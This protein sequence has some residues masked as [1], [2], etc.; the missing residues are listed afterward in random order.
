[1]KKI[2]ITLAAALMIAATGC[3]NSN[4]PVLTYVARASS[5]DVPHLFTL[6]EATQQSTAVSIAIPSDA[7]FVA[8]NSDATKVTYCRDASSGWDIFLMGTDNVEKQ[9]TT[10]ADACESVFSPDGKTIAYVSGVSGDLQIWTMNVDG[11]SQAVLYAPPSGILDQFLPEFSADGK[12]L[13]LYIDVFGGPSA[14]KRQQ[15]SS[16][17]AW[18]TE[19][20]AHKTQTRSAVAHNATAVSVS[21]WY[22]MPLSTGTPTLV[23]TPTT[24]WG[25]AVFSGDGTKLLFTDWDGTMYNVFSVK[26]DGSALTP[27]TT[28]TDTDN[29]SPVAYKDVILFNRINNSTSSWDI[30]VMNQD[31]SG[32]TLVHTTANT[33]ETLLDSYWSND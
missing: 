13:A 29:L 24:W 19:H 12:T 11:S 27:L 16:S 5:D 30:Y 7:D 10:G 2:A 21:G 3:G 18:L 28:S 32:Q 17:P 14:H 9:L 33:W 25:P 22:T 15:K 31:G 26:L 6:N 20:R 23:T 1:M 8:S 4:S